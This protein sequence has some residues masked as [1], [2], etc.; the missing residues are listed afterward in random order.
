MPAP[1][2]RLLLD[3]LYTFEA[4]ARHASFADA[5]QELGVTA[6]AVSHQLK[7]LEEHLGATLFDRSS[8][9]PV[10][11]AAGQQLAKPLSEVFGRIH[12]LVGDLREDVSNHLTISVMSAFGAK[13]L[14]PR[15]TDFCRKHSDL[16]VRIVSS[17][18]LAD[19]NND[20]I[21]VGIRFGAGRYEGLAAELLMEVEAFPVCS[22]GVLRDDEENC[23]ELLSRLVLLHDETALRAPGLVDWESWLRGSGH[24]IRANAGGLVFQNPQMAL[25]AA[26][27]GQGLALGLSPLVEDDLRAGRLIAPCPHV[28][29]SAFSF[30]VVCHPDRAGLRKISD[31]RHWIIGEAQ[32]RPQTEMA[33]RKPAGISEVSRITS[34]SLPRLPEPG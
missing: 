33:S 3:A 13:W 21:D 20:K 19:F 16:S 4:A 27:A 15:I 31:F 6:S 8:R 11:T 2:K 32:R 22:P 34:Q 25:E 10:L 26:L 12:A 1:R 30:W 23:R 5:A 7:R 29:R 18:I 9:G 14:A 28:Q 24:N 17:D